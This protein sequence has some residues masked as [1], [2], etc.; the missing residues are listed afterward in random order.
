MCN[1]MSK[2]GSSISEIVEA[3][4]SA[5]WK[6]ETKLLKASGSSLLHEAAPAMSSM[7]LL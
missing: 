6:L 3:N 2:R 4:G 1:K 7:Y 5:G